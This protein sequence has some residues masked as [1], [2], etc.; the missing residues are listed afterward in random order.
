M[1]EWTTT[2]LCPCLR[3]HFRISVSAAERT[4][5][6]LGQKKEH[7]DATG[8]EIKR[9][10]DNVSKDSVLYVCMYIQYICM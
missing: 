6:N 5:K 2:N 3:I 1:M 7:S 4:A 8:Y 9:N 10:L